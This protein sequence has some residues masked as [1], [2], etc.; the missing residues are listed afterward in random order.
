MVA[1]AGARQ[2]A[3]CLVPVAHRDAGKNETGNAL[4]EP[5]RHAEAYRAQAGYTNP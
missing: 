4:I 5:P 2:I 3:P 1:L